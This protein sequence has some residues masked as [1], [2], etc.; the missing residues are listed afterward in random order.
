[1]SNENYQ[2][3]WNNQQYLDLM[4]NTS[5]APEMGFKNLYKDTMLR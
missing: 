5:S 1:M 4:L 3:M 2:E